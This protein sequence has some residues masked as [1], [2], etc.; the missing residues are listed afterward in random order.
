MRQRAEGI[1]HGVGVEGGRSPCYLE[2]VF[3]A[4]QAEHERQE[5]RWDEL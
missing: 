5:E 1:G 3:E 4:C 2:R